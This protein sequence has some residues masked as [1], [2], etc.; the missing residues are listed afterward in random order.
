MAAAASGEQEAASMLRLPQI[1]PCARKSREEGSNLPVCF[2]VHY[3]AEPN[4]DNNSCFRGP[5]DYALHAQVCLPFV[6]LLSSITLE[7]LLSAFKARASLCYPDVSRYTVVAF[8][9]CATRL[10]RNSCDCVNNDISYRVDTSMYMDAT[11][12]TFFTPV[13]AGGSVTYDVY[14]VWGGA[15]E[16]MRASNCTSRP[17]TQCAAQCR[18]D[19]QSNLAAVQVWPNLPA[20]EISYPFTQNCAYVKLPPIGCLSELGED[21]LPVKMCP[22]PSARSEKNLAHSAFEQWIS[23]ESLERGDRKNIQDEEEATRAIAQKQELEGRKQVVTLLRLK[24]KGGSGLPVLGLPGRMTHGFP[25][26]YPVDT[27]PLYAG[28]G[29]DFIDK[30]HKCTRDTVRLSNVFAACGPR[31]PAGGDRTGSSR[32][33]SSQERCRDGIGASSS[34]IDEGLYS[35]GYI[36]GECGS[37]SEVPMTEM[38]KLMEQCTDFRRDLLTIERK[39]FRTLR[40]TFHLILQRQRQFEEECV[41][42]AFLEEIEE[43]DVLKI[44]SYAPLPEEQNIEGAWVLAAK[45]ASCAPHSEEPNPSAEV[46]EGSSGRLTEH[47]TRLATVEGGESRASGSPGIPT[48]RVGGYEVGGELVPYPELEDGIPFRDILDDREACIR[49]AVNTIARISSQMFEPMWLKLGKRRLEMCESE[50]RRRLH[51]EEVACFDGVMAWGVQDQKNIV[52][53]NHE[54]L[55]NALL[56]VVTEEEEIRLATC[57]SECRWRSLLTCMYLRVT[58]SLKRALLKEEG[59]VSADGEK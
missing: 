45:A 7:E 23:F 17:Q 3:D 24:G 43:A 16:D 9:T 54:E 28:H 19:E 49:E 52:M 1:F 21:M 57:N 55:V 40:A 20:K 33:P 46:R 39:E 18:G 56:P 50:E 31:Q 47:V 38:E 22:S 13:E 42:D 32:L 53:K 41:E 51:A 58:D 29:T 2:R 15:A 26:T 48:L 30:L 36:D 11:L 10:S 14:T 5:G 27:V 12:D 8:Y 34:W 6:K 25:R 44:E 4:E 35:D 59:K 37:S